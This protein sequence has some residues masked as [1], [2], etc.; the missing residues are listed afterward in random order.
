MKQQTFAVRI[1]K[2][3]QNISNSGLSSVLLSIHTDVKMLIIPTFSYDR[4]VNL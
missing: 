4:E 2:F 1:P 3:R